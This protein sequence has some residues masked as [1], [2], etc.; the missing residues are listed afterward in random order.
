MPTTLPDNGRRRGRPN[1]A[2][3]P[4]DAG[5]IEASLLVALALAV[6]TS[7][8]QP[9]LVLPA[10]GG[11]LLLLAVAS[12]AYA[13]VEGYCRGRADQRA[14]D[15]AG[16]LVLFAVAVLIVADKAEALQALGA[17]TGPLGLP[18]LHRPA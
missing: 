14:L 12:G 18:G 9:E 7:A 13:R 16:G 15:H 8:V 6:V 5:P 1:V 3:A 4:S 10:F 17:L 11:V 2:D